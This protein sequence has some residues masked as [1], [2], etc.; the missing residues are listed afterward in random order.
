MNEYSKLMRYENNIKQRKI[1]KVKVGSET[2]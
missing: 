1:R 2:N